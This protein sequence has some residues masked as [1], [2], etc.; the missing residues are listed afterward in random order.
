MPQLCAMVYYGPLQ[1]WPVLLCPC[2]GF[3]VSSLFHIWDHSDRQTHTHIQS[4]TDKG[5][6][7]SIPK[8]WV[9]G[10]LIVSDYT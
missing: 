9:L 4:R 7:G 10:Y 1:T 3:V 6:A 5:F 8:Y 2:F